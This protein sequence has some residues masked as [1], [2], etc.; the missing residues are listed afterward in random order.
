VL[1]S[2]GWTW[3]PGCVLLF[4]IYMPDPTPAQHLVEEGAA[5]SEAGDVAGAEQ[6][7]DDR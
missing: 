4:L 5:C 2:D 7:Y 3:P 6:A 1:E